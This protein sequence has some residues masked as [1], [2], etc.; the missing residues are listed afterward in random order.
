MFQGAIERKIVRQAPVSNHPVKY[1]FSLETD[2]GL[3]TVSN[4]DGGREPMLV[5]LNGR[6]TASIPDALTRAIP[7]ALDIF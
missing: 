1:E 5:F 4:A 7:G 3:V 2:W 6:C